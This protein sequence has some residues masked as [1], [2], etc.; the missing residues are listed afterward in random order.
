MIW[1][2]KRWLKQLKC[3]HKWRVGAIGTYVEKAIGTVDVYYLECW[4]CDKK[5]ELITYKKKP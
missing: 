1:F 2:V 3:N 5:K 4:N